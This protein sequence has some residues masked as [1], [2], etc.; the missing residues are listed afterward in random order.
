MTAEHDQGSGFFGPLAVSKY[1]ALTTFK[2]D[3]TP[4]VTPVNVVVDGD[5][6]FFRTWSTS[7]KAKRLRR[8]PRVELSPCGRRGRPRGETRLEATATVLQGDE[9]QAAAAALA[10]HYPVLHGLVVPRLHRLRGWT[11]QQYR[12]SPPGDR[13][14]RPA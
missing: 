14:G 10:R 13:P 5:A 8:S 7:G 6:A 4:V 12:L 3:G 11:T 2:R 9:S 1:C